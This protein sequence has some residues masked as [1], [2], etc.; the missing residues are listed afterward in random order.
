MLAC[1]SP[2]YISYEETINTL[3]YADR[4][5]QIKKNVVQNVKEVEVHISQYKEIIDSLR[6]EIT[7]LKA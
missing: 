7:A 1:V 3:K 2:S 5:K 6:N 4:A